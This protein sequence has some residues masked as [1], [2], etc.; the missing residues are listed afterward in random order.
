MRRTFLLTPLIRLMLAVA[1]PT[2]ANAG[3]AA[4]VGINFQDD[5]GDGGGAEVTQDA[6]G[7]PA[8]SWF[9][10]PRIHN[11]N[12]GGGVSSHATISLPGA[13]ALRVEWSC[14]NTYS[15]TG[16]VPVDGPGEDQV[17]Y[18]YLDDTAGGYRVRLSGLRNSL[19][20]YS[21]TLIAAT[22]GG[23]GFTDAQVVTGSGTNTLTYAEVVNPSLPGI[24]AVSSAG[25]VVS[26]LANN[27]AV[28]ITGAPRA[29]ANRSTLAGILFRYTPGGS[30]PPLVEA[31]PQAPSGSLFA[32]QAFALEVVASGSATLTYQWRQDGVAL[33]EAKSPTYR[34]AL[35]AASDSGEYDVIVSNGFGA[36]TSAVARVTVSEIVQPTITKAPSS[37]TL[38]AGYPAT[39]AVEATG[40]QLSYQWRKGATPI[41][42]ATQ[43][44]LSLSN[45]GIEDAETYSVEVTNAKGR[46]ES[47]AT[48]A[49]KIPV[50]GSYEAEMAQLQPLV[51]FRMSET[52]A[53]AQD[54]AANRG[55]L[56]AAGTGLYV[57][58]LSHGVG[59]ALV[60]DSSLAMSLAGG[61]VSVPFSEGLNPPESF[62]VECWAK[63]LDT[64]AGNRV[65]VQAM[66]NGE[67]A[68][69]A[70]D[71]SGWVLR[72]SGAN[73]EFL[74]GGENGAPFYTTVATAQ[75]AVTGGAW[76]HYAAVYHSD[77]PSVSLLVNGVVVTNVTAAEPLR[78]NFAAP[79]I[80]GDRG[81]GGWNFKG[82]LDEIAIYPTALGTA[83]L[84]AHYEAGSN[85]SSSA[86]YP[87]LVVADGAVEYLRLD[88]L[89]LPPTA[90]AAVNS[91]TLG[92]AA[93]GSYV[94][95]GSTLGR[96]FIAKGTEGPRP[97]TYP[98]LEAA[99]SSVSMTN[100]WVTAPTLSL[101]NQVTVTLWLKRDA[102][103]TTGDLSWPAWLG[104]GG[105]HLNLGTAA[106]PEAE[107]RYHWNGGAWDWSSGLFV[108]ADVWTFAAMVI[109][110]EVATFY[111]SDGTQLLSS[112]NLVSHAPMIVTSPPGFG[113]NQPGRADRTYLGRLD[114]TAVFDRALTPA[115]I[116][117]LFNRALGTG[118]TPPSAITISRGNL[119]TSFSWTQGVLQQSDNVAGPYTDVPNNPA[120][121]YPVVTTG[122]RMF[123]RLRGQ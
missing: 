42:G 82:S 9:S 111:M 57:G 25:G 17:A 8:G 87:S 100:G 63:P 54:T 38:Y 18:G 121:P 98:G 107:L 83:R 115:E 79:V 2:T 64:T 103:S 91:G 105:M 11:S 32:G 106:S 112:S 19:A 26:T 30:N 61:K 104:G 123:Y 10:M 84:L 94:D 58:G 44:T 66:I 7:V 31:P 37:Q 50:A 117:G 34:K 35:A 52:G 89:G 4:D 60:G 12:G 85:G 27:D 101:G 3:R 90:N 71:R 23:E 81:Y 13:G 110:P 120:S 56:G 88:D 29:G 20:S 36:V 78:R 93:T 16:D 68:D 14:E 97:A 46:A 41:A 65:L 122:A 96:S 28:V 62:T 22:D 67:N 49:V 51:Y 119:A 102:T 24:Y 21:V 72:Q 15:L 95:G 74:I 99:N 113:G 43:A 33:P 75:A 80:V 118:P 108:P 48:L 92:A 77:T 69:N 86:T 47:S 5:W 1:V 40:G 53:V 6:F 114:E 73:L 70:N 76:A 116:T 39:F 55:S 45:I 59:G 109:E